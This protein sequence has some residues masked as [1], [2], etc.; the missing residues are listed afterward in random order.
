[1]VTRQFFSHLDT[2]RGSSVLVPV[3]AQPPRRG[4]TSFHTPHNLQPS[5]N[6]IIIKMQPPQIEASPVAAGL[7][8]P[9]EVRKILMRSSFADKIEE[10]DDITL[11]LAHPRPG[12]RIGENYLE[13]EQKLR[14]LRDQAK[15]LEGVLTVKV[16]KHLNQTYGLSKTGTK[17]ELLERLYCHVDYFHEDHSK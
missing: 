9:P 6:I 1:V 15:P 16:L 17:A 4:T 14:G 8:V 5:K 12:T 7:N 13:A 2:T 10:M 3:S 11:E